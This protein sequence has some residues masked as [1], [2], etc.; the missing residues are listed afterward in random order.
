[1]RPIPRF[2][3]LAAVALC[4][5]ASLSAQKLPKKPFAPPLMTHMPSAEVETGYLDDAPYRIDV[6]HSWNR[7]L[8]VFYHGYSEGP[9]SYHPTHPLLD[10]V[11]PALERGYAV[12]ESGYSQPG[13]AIDEALA[14][15][16]SLR[17]YFIR[18]YGQP[19]ESIIIGSSM[20]GLLASMSIERTPK[21]YVGA[22]DLCGA[23]GPT[24]ESFNRR[25]AWRA[26]F[27]A[28]FPDLLPPLVPPPSSGYPEPP[29]ET[30]AT[31]R[32]IMDAL[33]THPDSALALRNLMGL[34]TDSDV[35]HII[36][37]IT[38]I[39]PDMQHK[40]RGNPF[41]NRNFLYTR[42]GTT[43]TAE[44]NRLNDMVRRYAADPAARRYLNDH[45]TPDGHLTKPM[46]ALH[47]SYDPL[48]PGNTLT[49]YD[50][51]VADAGY[52]DNLVQKYVHRDGHC[53][54]SAEEVGAAFDELVLWIHAGRRP[55]PGLLR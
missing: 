29:A 21:L 13:W 40:A 42:A 10:H 45:Y 16:E 2:G 35:A 26:A 32:R 1:M 55:A 31:L 4:L 30:E 7:S 27:D 48:I 43:S 28:Y 39:V 17:K 3:T 51:I 33:H 18:K 12:I 5:I 53:T 46:L 20:G 36:R 25:F 22:L 41:D 49:L 52:S 15:T 54:F 47:T 11:R 14:E 9:W 50:H 19:K 38:F 8:V 24:Y 34:H 6:P 37:Y 44:D 23:V